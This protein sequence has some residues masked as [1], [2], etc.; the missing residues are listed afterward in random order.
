[1]RVVTQLRP[2]LWQQART[3]LPLGGESRTISGA[4]ARAKIQTTQVITRI[5]GK[6]RLFTS[7]PSRR[8]RKFIPRNL[9]N[10][11]GFANRKEERLTLPNFSFS[12]IKIGAGATTATGVHDLIWRYNIR[13]AAETSVVLWT[14]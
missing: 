9:R 12:K 6:H 7:Q 3:G 10:A 4:R 8:A 2:L 5:R 14:P 13:Y 11:D 1:M